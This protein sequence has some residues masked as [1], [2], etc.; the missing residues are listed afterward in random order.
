MRRMYVIYQF[1]SVIVLLTM[2][3][4]YFNAFTYSHLK[5]YHEQTIGY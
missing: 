1:V 3:P 4:R 5:Q 2:N